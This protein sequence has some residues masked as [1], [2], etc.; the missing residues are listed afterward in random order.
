MKEYTMEE[1]L[2]RLKILIQKQNNHANTNTDTPEILPAQE[3]KEI[4]KY[5]HKGKS[6]NRNRRADRDFYQETIKHLQ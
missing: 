1:A 5:R 4:S 2:A 6:N 3:G